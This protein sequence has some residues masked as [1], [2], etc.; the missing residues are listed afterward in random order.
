MNKVIV[1]SYPGIGEADA[2]YVAR[3]NKAKFAI[4]LPYPGTRIPVQETIFCDLCDPT[5][6]GSRTDYDR[7]YHP[8]LNYNMNEGPLRKK[9]GQLR[10][11]FWPLVMVGG[12][13]TFKYITMSEYDE[14]CGECTGS[15]PHKAYH[16]TTDYRKA[17]NASH[18]E[19]SLWYHTKASYGKTSESALSNSQLI[20]PDSPCALDGKS[21]EN[22]D[23]EKKAPKTIPCPGYDKIATGYHDVEAEKRFLPGLGTTLFSSLG[24]RDMGE[25]LWSKYVRDVITDKS[26]NVTYDYHIEQ[27]KFVF[28]KTTAVNNDEIKPISEGLD[29]SSLPIPTMLSTSDIGKLIDSLSYVSI[30]YKSKRTLPFEPF[31]SNPN[32]LAFFGYAQVLV[33]NPTAT[34]LYTQDWHVKLV[35]ANKL[36]KALSYVEEVINRPPLRAEIDKSQLKRIVESL[37][38]GLDFVNQH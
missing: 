23:F 19:S 14:L 10:H 27:Y 31:L 33:Y 17:R 2:F 36:G 8:L 21:E 24:F 25:G 32:E 26:G 20:L 18:V 9:I 1:L 38:S 34:D 30:A 22:D 37:K 28:A 4:L 16:I 29:R 7:G 3:K 15:T 13:Y 12:P 5:L 35:P 11:L 6:N